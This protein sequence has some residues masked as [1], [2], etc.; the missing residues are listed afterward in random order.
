[1]REFIERQKK[2][3]HDA[4]VELNNYSG[5]FFVLFGIFLVGCTLLHALFIGKPV[6]IWGYEFKIWNYTL[7]VIQAIIGYVGIFLL[8]MHDNRKL[9]E[10]EKK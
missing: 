4:M 2:E 10:R 7:N 6:P 5:A 3:I 9:K 1:M 8:W